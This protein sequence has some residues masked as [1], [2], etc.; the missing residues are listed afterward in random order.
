MWNKSLGEKFQCIMVQ[1]KCHVTWH[2][3]ESILF[4]LAIFFLSCIFSMPCGKTSRSDLNIFSKRQEDEAFCLPSNE[5]RTR[6]LFIT[7]WMKNVTAYCYF[8]FSLSLSLQYVALFLILC[9]L[10]AICTHIVS[11][12]KLFGERS[13][14][15]VYLRTGIS[16]QYTNN[17]CMN[18]L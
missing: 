2:H 3:K 15:A 18:T 4:Q 10:L 5:V 17:Q 12:Y 8:V 7:D 13:C 11:V 16:M 1:K 14:S 9:V 6:S